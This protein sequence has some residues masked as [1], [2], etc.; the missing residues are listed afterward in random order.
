MNQPAAVKPKPPPVAPRCVLCGMQAC[1]DSDY[2][3]AHQWAA[4]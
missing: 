1:K 3:K 2:C 4:A